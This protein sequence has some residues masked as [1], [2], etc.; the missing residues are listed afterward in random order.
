MNFLFSE[1]VQQHAYRVLREMLRTFH[2]LKFNGY[3][4]RWKN[5]ENAL[6]FDEAIIV[7]RWSSFLGHGTKD[8]FLI[9]HENT[10][11]LL[12]KINLRQMYML[13]R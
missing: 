8:K 5:L 6:S 3:F 4:H 11:N 13:Q 10:A 12:H 9:Q 1:L 2:A 7:I